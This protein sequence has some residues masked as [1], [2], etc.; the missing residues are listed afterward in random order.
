MLDPGRDF[1]LIA[2]RKKFNSAHS[3]KDAAHNPRNRVQVLGESL[4]RRL[5]KS[6]WYFN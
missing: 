4:L 1:F 3:Y 2:L 6:S 5:L